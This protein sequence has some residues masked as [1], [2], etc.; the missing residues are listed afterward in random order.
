MISGIKH[1]AQN[2]GSGFAITRAL[3]CLSAKN[4]S[5]KDRAVL[6]LTLCHIRVAE[7][8]DVGTFAAG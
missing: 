5:V 6:E 8:D 4:L 1:V 3:K 7:F 2:C